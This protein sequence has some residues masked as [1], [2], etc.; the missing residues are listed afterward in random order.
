LNYNLNNNIIKNIKVLQLIDS[1]QIGGAEVMAVNIANALHK[2]GITSHIVVSRKEGP[3]NER[4]LLGGGY[5]CLNRK[6]IIDI[7]TLLKFYQYLKKH[8]INI[9]HA[10]ATS[11]FLAVLM[12]ILNPSLKIVWHD[13]FGDSEKLHQ[14]PVLLLKLASPFFSSIVS[15]NYKLQLW[16]KNELHTANCIYLPNF[17]IPLETL[18]NS[19]RGNLKGES[20]KRIVCLANLRPQKDHYNLLKAFVEVHKQFPDWTLHLIGSKSEVHYYKQLQDYIDQNNLRKS[21]VIY[22]NCTNGSVLLTQ[23]DIGVLSS[24]SEGLPLALLE[25]GWAQLGVVVTDVG[26]CGEVLQQGQNGLLVPPNNPQILAEKIVFLIKNE[27]E[28]MQLGQKLYQRVVV[29]YSEEIVIE[30]L[31]KKYQQ[32]G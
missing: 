29:T 6:K 18:S 25:Y 28:R 31:I 5:L 12:K 1:L 21:V 10:H 16:A 9:I 24:Q 13:H 3:L 30:Q 11:W 22:E 27:E 7:S 26:E 15:V 19:N 14:R 2:R 17:V 4:L 20:G 32:I 23:A 8:Q